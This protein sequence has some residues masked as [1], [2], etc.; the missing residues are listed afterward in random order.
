MLLNEFFAFLR[1]WRIIIVKASHI[2][3]AF[4]LQFPSMAQCHYTYSELLQEHANINVAPKTLPFMEAKRI[5]F[6]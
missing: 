4:A 5:T 6:P 1:T 2:N 3:S